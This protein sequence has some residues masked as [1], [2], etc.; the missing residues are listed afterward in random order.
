MIKYAARMK[1]TQIFFIAFG[2]VKVSFL[3]FALST[4]FINAHDDIRSLISPLAKLSPY[5]TT[6]KSPHRHR[7][8][9]GISIIITPAAARSHEEIEI[10]HHQRS[11]IIYTIP[12]ANFLDINFGHW[13]LNKLKT[14]ESPSNIYLA[15]RCLQ[16]Y[17]TRKFSRRQQI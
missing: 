5:L 16:I 6:I 13:A 11:Q 3:H 4:F 1:F 10:N 7:A 15:K 14:T 8:L 9:R 12:A 17:Q 2:C